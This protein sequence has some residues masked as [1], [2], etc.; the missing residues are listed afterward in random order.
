[1]KGQA[2]SSAATAQMPSQTVA[3]KVPENI[4]DMMPS[5]VKDSIPASV[6]KS[7]ADVKTSKDLENKIAELDSAIL[8]MTASRNELV[9]SR[10]EMKNAL[11]EMTA[12]RDDLTTMRSQMEEMRAAVPASFDEAE[13]NYLALID[14]RSEEIET[15]FQ[16][17]LNE[18]FRG[19]FTLVAVCS[20][21]GF[22]LVLF[23]RKKKE[24]N[25]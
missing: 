17:A 2:V 10:D 5:N 1:M 24:P 11:E 6:Q 4:L 13:N 9:S 16:A 12:S 23:Y 18:G 22:V 3:Q 7:L 14:E 21:I 25:D 20:V 15:T 8:S 19:M